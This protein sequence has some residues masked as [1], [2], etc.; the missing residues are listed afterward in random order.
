MESRACTSDVLACCTA[1]RV[2]KSGDGDCL[3]HRLEKLLP[4]HGWCKGQHVILSAFGK[5]EN[6]LIT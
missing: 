4:G 6:I 1:R 3:C 2:T 5:D